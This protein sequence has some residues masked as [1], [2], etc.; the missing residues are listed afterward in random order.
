MTFIA[1][2]KHSPKLKE[3]RVLTTPAG[4]DKAGRFL[5]EGPRVIEEL[6]KSRLAVELLL[7]SEEA[8]A[9]VVALG[10]VAA[11]RQIP[12]YSLP[13]A[14]LERWAPANTSQGLLAVA[15][16]PQ[17]SLDDLLSGRLLVIEGVQDPGNVGTLLRSALAFGFG[18]ALCLGG[19]D[20]YN[21]RAVRSS[22][23]ALF[24]MPVVRLA[25]PDPLPV[26][27]F[28]EQNGYQVAVA[29][30]HGGDELPQVCW[31]Q[32][33]ALVMGAEVAGVSNCLKKQAAIAVQIPLNPLSESLNVAAA[34]AVL[35]YEIMRCG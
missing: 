23:G 6:L 16:L 21:S 27:A 12:V 19:A 31:P 35:M 28:L 9:S 2:G 3:L 24:H 20:P 25:A 4:R 18:G 5:V 7:C 1:L 26:A 34:G 14:V 30:A 33:L 11:A 8:S 17:T 10:N 13:G 29:V 22:A 15:A 32:K